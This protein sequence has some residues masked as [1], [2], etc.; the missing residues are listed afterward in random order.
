[1][2][3]EKVDKKGVLK[4][5]LIWSNPLMIPVLIGA[6]IGVVDLYENRETAMIK[7]SKPYFY[8]NV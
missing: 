4:H 7:Y 2:N 5:F 3:S 8:K 1:M 6:T